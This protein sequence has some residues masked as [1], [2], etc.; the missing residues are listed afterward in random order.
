MLF[1]QQDPT[2][3]DSSNQEM[4]TH[5]SADDETDF[6]HQHLLNHTSAEDENARVCQSIEDYKDGL[7]LLRTHPQDAFEKF[8]IAAQHGH[9]LAQY[10][11]GRMLVQ[12]FRG[13]QN[14]AEA[15]KIL[16]F[17]AKNGC[18]DAAQLYLKISET[19][20]EIDKTERQRCLAGVKQGFSCIRETRTVAFSPESSLFNPSWREH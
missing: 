17:S 13:T 6:L 14:N 2:S 10:K 20:D 1:S 12:Y 19:K 18:V 5:T 7:I 16:D 4:S 8:N 9:A 15:L 11:C 3:T